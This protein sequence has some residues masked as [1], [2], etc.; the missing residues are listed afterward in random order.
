MEIR[1]PTLGESVTEATV[2]QWYKTAGEAVTVDEPLV[3]LETDKVT[4]EVPAPMSGTLSEILVTDGQTVEVG[5]LL[6]SIGE[7]GASVK[8]SQKPAEK[9]AEKPAEAPVATPAQSAKPDLA[10]A[11]RRVVAEN[12]LDACRDAL[13]RLP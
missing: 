3:E 8:V 11:A 6:G 5:A 7:G 12:N 13:L 1:V 10:P 2:A 4:I 9:S